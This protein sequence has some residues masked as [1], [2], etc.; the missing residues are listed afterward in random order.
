MNHPVAG[1][2]R[3]M[4]RAALVL[5]WARRQDEFRTD[6]VRHAHGM[7]PD[8]AAQVLRRLMLGGHLVRVKFGF[9]R[10]AR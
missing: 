7:T 6:D 10:A 3:V 4:N 2:G 5:A 1:D 8:N 9:Y